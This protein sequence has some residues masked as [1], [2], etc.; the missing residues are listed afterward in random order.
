MTPRFAVVLLVATTV[1]CAAAGCRDSAPAW[2]TRQAAWPAPIQ[3][4]KPW[5]PTTP[6]P[7]GYPMVEMETSKGTVRI[8]LWPDKAPE[9]VRNFLSY[10][11]DGHYDG[12]IFHRVIPNF[13][14]QGGG[15]TPDMA[16]K[17]TKAPIKNEAKAEVANALATLAMARTNVVDSAT[18]Q[19]F[20]NVKD[21]AFLNHRD[22]T[23]QGFGYC[24]F[25]E[26]TE[27]WDVVEQIKN[28]PTATKGGY[29]NVPVEPVMIKRMTRMQTQ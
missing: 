21:N 25:G 26:V 3:S 15:F 28:V 2:A 20:I 27:G 12:T 6:N 4:P 16:Q 22:E 5:R 7:K 29:E 10:V 14:I 24:V 1:S 11:D 23:D 17:P 9:T 18:A 8:T 13:M 19:F